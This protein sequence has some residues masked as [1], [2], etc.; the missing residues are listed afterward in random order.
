MPSL[1]HS[2]KTIAHVLPWPAVGGTEH[3]TLRIATTVRDHGFESIAFCLRGADGVQALF[4]NAG[5]EVVAFDPA[6]PSFRRPAR[7]LRDINDLAREFRRRRV[8]LLHCAD[9]AGALSAGTAGKLARVPVVCH[10]RNK[11]DGLTRRE[12]A[13]LSPVDQFVFVSKATWQHFSYSVGPARGRVIYDA[14]HVSG[15]H[16][17]VGAPSV[18]GELGLPE[19]VRLVGM[20]ARVS[21]QKDFVTLARAAARVVQAL[22]NTRF[23]IVGDTTSEEAHRAHY[24]RIQEVLGEM[25]LRETF[26]FTGFRTDV[27]RLVTAFDVAVLSTHWEGLPLSVIE[28]MAL[29][30]P[31]VATGVD[32]IPE[33][34][35]NSEV[36]LLFQPGDDT[37]LARHLLGLLS[38]AETAKRVG[39]AGQSFIEA[40]FSPQAFAANLVQ[41]YAQMTATRQGAALRAF[42]PTAQPPRAA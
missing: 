13:L 31:T 14:A 38:D 28:S 18:R 16:A 42:T 30:I 12:R 39:R 24:A 25:G 41:L 23:I 5:I 7:Y 22:P 3:A 2:S 26:I 15:P 6:E 29:G 37:T 21:P 32:G 33:V 19:G 9:V 8:G 34:I 1:Q 20:V 4:R 40:A 10:V 11:F 17:A 35:P 36:G 27:T